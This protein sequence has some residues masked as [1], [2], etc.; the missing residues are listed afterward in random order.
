MI[1]NRALTIYKHEAKDVINTSFEIAELTNN[2]S[3]AEGP[4][5]NSDGYYL[6]SDIPVNTIYKIGPQTAKQVFIKNSGCT[7]ADTGD[8][9]G[10]VGSNGL[11][12]DNEGTLLICQHGNGTV[13]KWDG[14]EVHPFIKV[15]KGARF[16]SPNDIVVHPNGTVFFTDPPYGLKDQALAPKT[17]QPLA[18]LYGFNTGGVSLI[19]TAFEYPNGVCL[20]ND[21]NT[22]YC[23]S[24]KPFEKKILTFDAHTFGPTG[25][26]CKENSDGIKCDKNGN[27]WLCAKEGLVVLNGDGERLAKIE[28]PTIPSN[29]CWGGPQKTDLLVTARENVFLLQQLLH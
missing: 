9:S 14:S 10:Q 6:F 11:T 3:F 23:C 2:C 21:G 27:F 16:N 12:Y 4:V 7:I 20:S 24:S 22:L 17:A 26:F 19:S 8:L 29:C 1:E 28:L 25:M 5:W 15:F 13:A 18:G